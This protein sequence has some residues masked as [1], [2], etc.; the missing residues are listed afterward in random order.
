M[1]KINKMAKKKGIL[2]TKY[3]Q[4]TEIDIDTNSRSYAI[5][6]KNKGVGS[7]KK[8]C[9]WKLS[10]C[11]IYLYGYTSG[12]ERMI[13]KHELPPPVDTKLYFGDLLV[14][15]NKDN[16]LENFTKKDYKIFWNNCFGGFENLGDSEEEDL[17]NSENDYDYDDPFI[18]D[19]R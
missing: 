7:C 8:L 4:I 17:S 16:I 5:Y 19:D 14:I 3:G 18:V 10:Y 12:R 1:Y 6:F 13:N 15:K 11:S 9:E 2:I